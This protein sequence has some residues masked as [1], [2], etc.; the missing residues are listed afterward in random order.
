MIFRCECCHTVFSDPRVISWREN[1]DGEN[2]IEEVTEEL[3]PYCG[4]E[5]FEEVEDEEE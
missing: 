3:C 5:W 1:L 2:G 4:C